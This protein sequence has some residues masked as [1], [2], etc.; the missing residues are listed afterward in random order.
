MTTA[1][2]L[3]VRVAAFALTLFVSGTMLLGALGPATV[4][5]AA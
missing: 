5:L 4:P 1:T 2:T 3:R